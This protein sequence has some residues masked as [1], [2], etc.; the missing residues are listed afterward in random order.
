M[1]V[2][3]DFF[4]VRVSEPSLLVDHLPRIRSESC[5]PTSLRSIPGIDIVLDGPNF[6]WLSLTHCLPYSLSYSDLYPS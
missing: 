5:S 1:R 6:C 3:Y 4:R 2:D